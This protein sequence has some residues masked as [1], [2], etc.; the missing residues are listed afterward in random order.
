MWQGVI[1]VA[2]IAGEVAGSAYFVIVLAVIV[3][4]MRSAPTGIDGASIFDNTLFRDQRGEFSKVFA[5]SRFSSNGRFHQVAE[6]F[7]SASKRDVVRGM[8]YQGGPRAQSK[9]VTVVAGE[10]L[11]V[12]L[13]LRNNSPTFGAVHSQFLDCESGR[14]VFIPPGVAHG[15]KVLSASATTL[16]SV[17]TE[18]AASLDLGVRFDSFGFSWPGGSPIVSDRDRSLP[19]FSPAGSDS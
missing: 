18:Y 4:T 5:S 3:M 15:F 1:G 17:S 12:L 10:I 2:S 8:H 16:Y 11:D 6:I 9:L 19:G 14:S 7:W 13:D